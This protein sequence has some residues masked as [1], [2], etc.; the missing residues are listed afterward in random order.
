LP[1]FVLGLCVL[2]KE[3]FMRLSPQ[4][5]LA[6]LALMLMATP[7]LALSVDRDSNV[8]ADG[9][10][11]FAD[12]DDQMPNFMNGPP[13]DQPPAHAT[14]SIGLPVTPGSPSPH[15]GFS[16]NGFANSSQ[17]DAFDQAYDRK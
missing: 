15:L 6:A 17:P 11:K 4:L 14:P 7:A 9:T 1:Y 3:D 5:S 8:N 2:A 12:P 10:A 16:V 13:E